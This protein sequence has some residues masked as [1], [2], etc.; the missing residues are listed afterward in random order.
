MAAESAPARG[1]ADPLFRHFTGDSVLPVSP[2]RIQQ[3]RFGLLQRIPFCP[4]P[5]FSQVS[6]RV[7]VDLHKPAAT[8]SV[9]EQVVRAGSEAATGRRLSPVQGPVRSGVRAKISGENG[10]IG[11]KL[12]C[13]F[14]LVDA[15]GAGQR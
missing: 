3:A 10:F 13:G 5:P 15:L 4:F 12:S 8:S 1:L 14:Q 7:R 11:K 9:L 6:G 2:G